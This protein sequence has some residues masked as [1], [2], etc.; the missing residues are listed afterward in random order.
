MRLDTRPEAILVDAKTM[1]ILVVDMQNDFA[2]PGGMFDRAGIPIAAIDAIVAP[3]R[4]VLDAA[5]AAGM[6]VV[7]LKMQFAHHL[8]DA[9]PPD[10]PNRIKHRP[11]GLGEFVE[12][13]AGQP[14][15]IL[16][17]GTWNT[18]IV[19]ELTPE[20][21]DVIVSKHRYSG[22]YETALDRTLRD[23]GID[24]LVFTGATTSVCVESTVRDAL[25]R[26]Y[27]CVLLSDCTAEPIGSD[28]SPS[29]HDATMLVI[30]TL[31]GWVCEAQALLDALSGARVHHTAG[32]THG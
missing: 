24:T 9:G 12:T 17:E 10:T 21:G 16:I 23:A 25:Y 14:G 22:F 2:A 32:A 6:L 8:A 5:R 29:N 20:P 26:D 1:A 19:A 11:L 15:Q 27:R 28:R 3:T 30:E 4:S 31:F 7:F 13:P 18:E